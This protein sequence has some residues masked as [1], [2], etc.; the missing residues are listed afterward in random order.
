MAI[1]VYLGDELLSDLPL[2]MIPICIPS[3]I[4]SEPFSKATASLNN[5][6]ELYGPFIKQV[7]EAPGRVRSHSS[8]LFSCQLICV[9][10]DEIQYTD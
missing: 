7:A 3:D 2:S 8:H 5:E 10:K 9:L 6:R 4:P 1:V